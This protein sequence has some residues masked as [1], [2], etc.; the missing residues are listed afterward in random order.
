[1]TTSAGPET[2]PAS[3]PLRGLLIAQFCGAFN[4]NA[5]KLMVALLAI[6]QATAGMA[7]GPELETVAQTQTAMAFVVFTLPL[8]LLSLVGGT[9]ADR[10]SKRTVIISIKVVEVVLMTAGTVALWLNPAGGVL[11]LVVLCGMGVHSAL[12]S[13][14]KYGILPELVPHE[15][16][17]SG[18]GLLEMW[19]FAA[20]LTGTAAGGFLLQAVG[21]QP[22]LAPLVLTALSVI[23]LISAFGIPPVSPA[24]M[25]GGVDAT[26][27]G[28][29]AAIQS[30]RMLR[31]AIPMEI[32]FW[33]VASL[34]GQNVLVYAKAVLHLSDG[35]SGLPLTILSVGIGIGAMLVGRISKNR[36]EYGLIP[37]GAIG[38][39]VILLLLGLLTPPLSGTFLMMVVLGISSSFIFV[40]LNAILQWKSPSDR[41]G[42]VISF[43]N[44]CVFT[45]ILSGSLAGGSLA[46]VGI[47]TTGIF[48]AAAAMTLA[49]VGW[50]LWSLPD[51]F[52][53]FVLVLLTNTMYRLRIVGEAHVP[54][55]GGALLVPN[56]V[57][58]IDGF[59]LIASVDRPVRFVVDS[60]YAE[61]PIFKPFMNALGAIPI[62]SH[63]GLRV[64]LRA[65][66]D[67]GAAVDKGELV[68]IFPE[69]QITRTGT[70]LP[71]RRGF[72]RIV[73][74]RTVPIIPVHLDRVWG[75]IFSFNHG[76]FLWKMPE[77][78]PYPVTVSFGAPLP[79]ST[80]AHELRGKIRE[81][82]EAA[83]QLRKPGRRPLHRQFI[84]SMR[85]APFLLAMADQT[86]PRVSSLQALIGSIVLARTLRPHWQ[87]QDR[88]GV[89]LP[90]TVAAALVNVAAPLCGKTIVN[91]NYT[92]GKSGLEAAVHLAGLRTVV[93]SH[94][95]VEKAKLELPSGPSVIWLEDAAKTVGL[96]D[97]IIAALLALFAPSRLI[98]RA[99]GQ[100]TPLTPDSLA[101]IIFSS[102]STGEPKGVMLS[103]FSIDMNSQ[104]ATQ[105]LH[106][107]QDERVLGILPFFHSFGYMVFWFV[108][109]NNATMIF[110]PSPL[111]VAAIGELIRTYRITFL[112]TTPT[113]LQLYTRRCTPEQFSS[114][115]VILTGAE[116]LPAR[117]AQAIEDKFGVGPIEGYGVTECAPVI[118]VNC[119]DFR[120]AGYYQPASRRGTVGQPLPGV[121]VQIVDPDSFAPL[122]AGMPG[123]LL[124]RGPNVMNGYLGREDLTAQV[125][126]NGW[127]IT[128]DIA[129]L[130]EDGFLTITD[131]LS[132][133]SKIGGE[134]VPHGKVEEALQQAAG[135]D[136]QVFAV[137]GLPD[138]KKGERLAVLHTLEESHISEI[139]EKVSASGLPNLFIPGRHQFVKV[140]ALPVLGTGKLDLRAVKRMAMERL[141]SHDEVQG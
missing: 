127:Y 56:H 140:E 14:S 41:R 76:R 105:V 86:R 104:G 77:R 63:G 93:T 117:L 7:P 78:L 60:Q 139:L 58:F 12:F 118:A 25:A 131:R 121:S 89:L 101:T 38:V 34:F 50:A 31:M 108:M 106:L 136:T 135:A 6:R 72:E 29:W 133:F 70:L 109:F 96:G 119:P 66:R 18:N 85:R 32:L 4:D 115:R 100:T 71:F 80:T 33:T 36:V 122:P 3:H 43:S 51:T 87:G 45:G 2:Q 57:S 75:S 124:V 107:Y 129:S 62:T 49:G 126:R 91:L 141:S 30:E 138:E 95:F 92:V 1:M 84:S 61:Q 5:W 112:V 97:K 44:T 110:H 19:T 16:L 74:G 69:G 28:A 23:G 103:H 53:R 79:P 125:M 134:M 24:R 59:L 11:P 54:Q 111:D 88:V 48:L 98:E 35:M 81:L 46:N 68:C 102:G 15:R 13:P 120:A 82:G 55:S 42:A 27:Q 65:L 9:L 10:V 114:I 20:I 83:W 113:F 130:D 22:W 90:P 116:K 123:M 64:I 94:T 39:F 67:A 73:K 40:P 99:C 21:E 47:S 17:A 8:V 132:R 137:T 128:G 26:I 37:L 52:L